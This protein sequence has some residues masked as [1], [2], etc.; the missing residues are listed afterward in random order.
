MLD[1]HNRV[2][3]IMADIY[4]DLPRQAPGSPAS[5]LK[6]FS[7]CTDLPQH[8]RVLDIGCGTGAQTIILANALDGT[9]IAI[10]LM[11]S[12][13]EKLAS[14]AT[15]LGLADKIQVQA[16]DMGNLGFHPQSIDLIWA[17]GSAY[18]IGFS[19]ALGKWREFLKPRA[20]LAV[21]ELVWLRAD[22]PQEVKS[23]F[24]DEYP[25]MKHVDAVPAIFNDNGYELLEQFTLPDECWWLYYNPII[26]KLPQ[27]REQYAEDELALS[28]VEAID[29]EIAMR[30][31]FSDWYGYQF[32]IA[33]NQNK[34]NS[35]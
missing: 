8:P 35:Q 18:S 1:D 13:V 16:A 21:S 12:F 10:D 33:R 34:S 6:A 14:E 27:L 32:F 25:D 7:L 9:I 20:Y 22:P 23:F 24:A 2:M 30:R 5:T 4:G 15:D 26:A 29:V 31:R 19:N 28:I 11:E 17:E 3:E